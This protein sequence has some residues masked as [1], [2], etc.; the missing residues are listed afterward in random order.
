LSMIPENPPEQQKGATFIATRIWRS[1]F[2][3]KLAIVL[4]LVLVGLTLIG[5]FVIQIPSEYTNDPQNYLWWLE[6]VAQIQTGAWYPLLR[7]L[8]FFNLFHSFWFILAGLMLVVNII[9]CSLNRLNQVRHL[10]SLKAD[11]LDKAFFTDSSRKEVV[12]NIY[13]ADNLVSFLKKRRYLVVVTGEKG[14]TRILAVKN[15]FSPAGTYM[16]HLS[17]ILFILGFLIGH[18]WGF[19]NNSFVVT[20]GQTREIGYNT[21]L[22]LKLENFQYDLYPDGSPKNYRSEIILLKDHNIVK[23]GAVEVNHPL[24]YQGVRFYQSFYGAAENIRISRGGKVIY[25]GSVA[26]DSTMDNHPYLRPAGLLNLYEQGYKIYL[27]S[28]ATNIADPVLKS[29][30]LGIEVYL[31]NN[32]NAAVATILNLNTPL[33]AGDLEISY[34]GSGYYSGFLVNSD[35]GVGVIWTGSIFLLVGLI[36]VFYFPRRQLRA[37]LI[38]NSGDSYDLYLLWDNSSLNSVDARRL[39]DLLKNESIKGSPLRTERE[40]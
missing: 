33:S 19:Q 29:N 40:N 3:L 34:T 10:L 39:T 35:P 26:L 8:G 32:P 16:I 17:I 22:S 5:T 2:S 1:F 13:S 30:Q 21:G 9:V 24:K 38:I 14:E 7:L 27:V 25:D 6:N 23:R 20:E 18:Y 12:A 15:R 4:I 11:I 31:D 36:A 28:P 37:A